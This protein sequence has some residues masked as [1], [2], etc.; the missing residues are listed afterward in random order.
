MSGKVTA[1]HYLYKNNKP[2]SLIIELSCH[3]ISVII[4]KLYIEDILSREPVMKVYKYFNGIKNYYRIMKLWQERKA[5]WISN[6]ILGNCGRL[7][8]HRH[9]VFCLGITTWKY[10]L[11][12]S[13]V[14]FSQIILCVVYYMYILILFICL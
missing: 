8:T 11:T 4:N 7:I 9:C 12:V 14:T 3:S 5:S 10:R 1:W 2:Q 13:M 6:T